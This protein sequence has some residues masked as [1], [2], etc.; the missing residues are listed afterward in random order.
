MRLS[1]KY[2]HAWFRVLESMMQM[3]VQHVKKRLSSWNIC[4]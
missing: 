1:F 2:E 4:E 3:K